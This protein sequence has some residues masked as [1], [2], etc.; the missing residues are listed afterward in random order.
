[1]PPVFRH[2]IQWVLLWK[3]QNPLHFTYETFTLFGIL[4]QKTSAREA[5]ILMQSRTPHLLAISSRIRFA[6]CRVRSL[7]ITASRLISFP[8]GTKTFQSPALFTIFIVSPKRRK[9]Y[10]DTLGSQAACAYPRHFVA[11][12]V[13]LHLTKPSHPSNGLLSIQLR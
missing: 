11:C 6:L 8:A 13:L 2:N 12:H 1:M 5:R 7:L 9:S 3:L 4:F 10:S